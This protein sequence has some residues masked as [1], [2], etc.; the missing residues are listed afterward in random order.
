M[1]NAYCC[2]YPNPSNRN[3]DMKHASWEIDHVT[4]MQL[5]VQKP[6]L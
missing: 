1:Q 2:S 4:L 3:N 6:Q 5:P